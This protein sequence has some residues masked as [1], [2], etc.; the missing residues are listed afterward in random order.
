MSGETHEVRVELKLDRIIVLLE[1]MYF[2]EKQ[3]FDIGK[4]MV[5][6]DEPCDL[7]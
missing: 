6:D 7:E 3:A 5:D 2:I 4:K 1:K